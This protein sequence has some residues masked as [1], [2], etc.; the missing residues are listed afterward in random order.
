MITPEK[1]H[2]VTNLIILSEANPPRRV[3]VFPHLSIKAILSKVVTIRV[4]KLQP[5]T[6]CISI[7]LYTLPP[8]LGEKKS[9]HLEFWLTFIWK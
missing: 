9:V 1:C 6:P 5:E 2:P 3:K 4:K 7:V 8:G